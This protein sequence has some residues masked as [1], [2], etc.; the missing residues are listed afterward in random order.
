[1]KFIALFLLLFVFSGFQS[2]SVSVNDEINIQEWKVPWDDT[3]PRDPYVDQQGRVW[4]C[5]QKGNY[6]AYL[7]PK[8]GEFKRYDILDNTHPHNL[9][10]DDQGMVWYAGNK[11]AHIGT[12][13]PDTGEIKQYP[14]PEEAARD[15]HTL[16]F[17]QNGDIWFTVQGGNYIGKLMT[18]T[19]EVKLVKVLT[20]RARPY[21][22]KMDSNNRPWVVLFGTNKIATVDPETME[23]EEIELPRPETRPR[24]ME[25]TSDNTVW[26]VDYAQGYLGSLNTETREIKEWALPSGSGA[27]PYGTAKD[28]KDRIW[29]VE[30]GPKP[31]KVVLFD[32]KTEQFTDSKVVPSGGGTIRYMYFHPS[33]KEIWFGADS[34]TVGRA[35]M[36]SGISLL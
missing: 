30:T 3:R 35:K 34:N 27:R 5:G 8:T 19:G 33:T 9:I 14:M 29:L 4:F 32:T 6:I 7:E 11:N 10:V 1:M 25:I 17:D 26:Y 36:Q 16:V 31:N 13:N 15:P 2:D 28:D 12:L 21:G 23:L 22:I 18:K 20:S 24:R